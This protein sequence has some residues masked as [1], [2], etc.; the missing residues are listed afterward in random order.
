MRVSVVPASVEASLV[1]RA[2]SLPDERMRLV[3]VLSVWNLR[4]VDVLTGGYNSLVLR[5]ESEGGPAVLK[6]PSIPASVT[7]EAAALRWWGEEVAPRVLR[8]DE[9]L[10]AL[11]IELLL[12]G[13][14]LA[15]DGVADSEPML[16]LLR[17]MQ[18]DA[19]QTL[20]LPLLSELAH[21][22]LTTM[23]EN[24]AKKRDLVDEELARQ[25]EDLLGQLFS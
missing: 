11:L 7:A 4:A 9:Q 12:P 13:T 15:W 22:T 14:L 2:S 19:D 8:H 23:Q 18:R 3:E 6:L 17:R 16:P 1:E 21:R 20:S 24:T 5:V 25:A 10:G